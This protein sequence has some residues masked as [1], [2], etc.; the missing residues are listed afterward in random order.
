MAKVLLCPACKKVVPRE[1][2]LRPASFPFCCDRCKM[3]DLGRW[4][5]EEYVAPR[6]LGPDDEE[7]IQE[8]LRARQGEG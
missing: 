6:P 1:D 3:A 7:A 4:F 8:V 5:A 2:G